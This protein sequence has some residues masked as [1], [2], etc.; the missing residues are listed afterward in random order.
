MKLQYRL[1]ATVV[2]AATAASAFVAKADTFSI[3]VVSG[4]PP[5]NAGVAGIRDFFIPEV[6]RRLAEAGNHSISWTEAYGGSVADVQGVLEAVEMGIG[7][8]GYVPH[9]FEG[10]KLPLEQI[11]YLAP[12][13]TG[14]LPA[15]M[16]VIT[17]L[18][19]EIPEMEEAWRENN[20]MVLAPVGIDDYQIVSNFPISSAA[21]LDGRRIG[22]AGLALNWL[23]GSGA[24]P[25]AGALTD[26]Y[27][28]MATGLIDGAVTFESAVA[29]YRFH[30]V[31]PHVTMI[32]YGAK[33]ASALT[34]NL[35]VWEGL[36]DEVQQVMLAVSEE[37]RLRTAESYRSSG[38]NSLAKAAEEGATIHILDPEER[39]HLAE[40]L[41]NIA[42]EWARGLDARGLPGTRTLETYLALSEEAG[43][44]FARDWLN[45]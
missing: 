6:D 28:S 43:L 11:T 10:D 38:E 5:V 24:T 4:H 14:D 29:G 9:L 32:G 15:L 31:A 2:V 30:E 8:M 18:H 27:N 25:V 44:T 34:I 13:S 22:T 1:A 16:E 33:Y 26:F 41:P 7:D 12:F 35:D 17:R 20:Q 19:Q 39:A 40:A 42:L 36:P 21:D 3:T 23:R 45:E 37:Y